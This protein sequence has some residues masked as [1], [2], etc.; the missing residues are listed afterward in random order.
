MR[1][2]YWCPMRQ[3]KGLRLYMWSFA[4]SVVL[5][6]AVAGIASIPHCS[7]AG[8]LLFPGALLAAVAFPQGV[9][10]TGGNAYLVVAGLLD[11]LLFALPVMFCWNVM[12][13]KRRA[14][15]EQYGS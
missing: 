14:R 13:R 12:A 10:S 4:I 1:R 5:V 11:A 15:G 7:S 8:V 6:A 2:E 3:V 9:N